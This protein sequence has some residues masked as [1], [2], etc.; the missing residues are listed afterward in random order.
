MFVIALL[1]LLSFA[2]SF[3]TKSMITNEWVEIKPTIK[4]SEGYEIGR[5]YYQS[6]SWTRMTYNS[7][8]QKLFFYDGYMNMTFNIPQTIYAN[9]LYEAD[10]ETDTIRM[11]LTSNWRRDTVRSLTNP[12]SL[13]TYWYNPDSVSHPKPFDRHTYG[14]F[15]YAAH[16]NSIYIANG[17]SGGNAKRVQDCWR[18]SFDESRWIFVD[19]VR[20]H[21]TCCNT[22]Y[23]NHLMHIPGSNKMYQTIRCQNDHICV[24][25]LNLDSHTWTKL[26]NL[27][28]SNQL[29]GAMG[30]ADTKR[31][32]YVFYAGRVGG[33][34][35]NELNVYYPA[36]HRVQK[37]VPK[38]DSVPGGAAYPYFA[39]DQKNDVYLLHGSEIGTWVYEPDTD[40]WK[41][42]N[43]VRNPLNNRLMEYH[44]DKNAFVAW[45]ASGRSMWLF[46][47]SPDNVKAETAAGVNDE[48]KIS[49]LPNPF[50]PSTKLIIHGFAGMPEIKITIYNIRGEIVRT[51]TLPSSNHSLK[52]VVFNAEELTAG[53]YIVRASSG[54]ITV[55]KK[56]IFI[57]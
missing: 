19:T 49:A 26:A 52:T 28:Q 14:C 47:Y 57:K 38:S 31:N 12:D 17:A 41:K 5:P 53:T 6:R 1:M 16:T 43:T 3:D 42:I 20:R 4:F 11:V 37:L 30:T 50:N 25:E 13:I 34:A 54:N 23:E 48:I 55:E 10:F 9:T 32:R 40:L 56:I 51:F 33:V 2:Y 27:A 36:E 24:W 44:A 35:S 15:L 45:D 29:W 7:Q 18:Y 39:Y 22:E 8:S 46:R 21:L